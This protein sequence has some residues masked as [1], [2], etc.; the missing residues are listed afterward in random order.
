ME[1]YNLGPIQAFDLLRL[2]SQHPLAEIARRLVD[3]EHPVNL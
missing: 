2:L 1:R 3:N